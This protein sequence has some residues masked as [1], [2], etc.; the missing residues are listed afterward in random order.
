MPH[1]P[2]QPEAHGNAHPGPPAEHRRAC[3]R[4]PRASPSSTPRARRWSTALRNIDSQRSLIR[5]SRDWLYR[6]SRAWEP[7]LQD[8]EEAAGLPEAELW[9][10]I[11]R[12]YRFLAPRYMPVQE[13]QAFVSGQRHGRAKP[14]G[15]VMTLV[16]RRLSPAA[17]PLRA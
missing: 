4:S 14:I 10:L 2:G 13:W 6:L 16:S 12:T 11:E 17:P 3:N 5:S 8:W 1:R 9:Q 7:I 15:S